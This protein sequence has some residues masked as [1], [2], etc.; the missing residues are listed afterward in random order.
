MRSFHALLTEHHD[1]WRDVIPT[2]L[3]I[4]T[5]PIAGADGTDTIRIV[6]QPVPNDVAGLQD[7]VLGDSI[8][9]AQLVLPKVVPDSRHRIEF[10]RIRR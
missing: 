5:C 8:H 7:L 9:D 4:D 2:R 10:G 1:V 6:N 3:D